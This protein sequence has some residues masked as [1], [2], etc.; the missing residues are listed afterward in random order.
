MSIC[1]ADMHICS[2]VCQTCL[3]GQYVCINI[4]GAKTLRA[5][6][7]LPVVASIGII[8]KL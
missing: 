1:C 6:R 4:Q 3:D 5:I 7:V 8:V 2:E